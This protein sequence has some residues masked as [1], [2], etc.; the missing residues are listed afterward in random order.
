V[1]LNYFDSFSNISY[2]DFNRFDVNVDLIAEKLNVKPSSKSLSFVQ[3][4][5]IISSFPNNKATEELTKKCIQSAKQWGKPIILTSH[6]PV[7]KELQE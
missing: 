5:I 6:C 2:L 7:S 3:D 1:Y 4:V